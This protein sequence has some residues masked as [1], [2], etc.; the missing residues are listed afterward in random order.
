MSSAQLLVQPNKCVA[1]NQGRECF[2]ELTIRWQQNE[3]SDYCLFIQEFNAYPRLLRCWHDVNQAVWQYEFQS[4]NDSQFLLMKKMPQTVLASAK[5]Q[6][7][8]LYKASIRKRRW[9]LF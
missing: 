3:T 6:V 5:V 8:W 7:S 2:A 4:T 1:L 9:R